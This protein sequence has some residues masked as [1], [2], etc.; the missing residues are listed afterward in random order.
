MRGWSVFSVNMSARVRAI[1]CVERNGLMIYLSLFL[2]FRV[3]CMLKAVHETKQQVRKARSLIE[4]NQKKQ[5]VLQ[6]KV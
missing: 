2:L 4:S 5:E 1:A 6:K 3:H